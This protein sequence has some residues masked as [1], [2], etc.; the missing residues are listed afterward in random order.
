[1]QYKVPFYTIFQI[2]VTN[3]R[4][5]IGYKTNKRPKCYKKSR[6][7]IYLESLRINMLFKFI[8]AIALLKYPYLC[9]LKKY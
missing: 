3:W 4:F 5:C 9:T 7:F 1:M 8:P 2:A 6:I